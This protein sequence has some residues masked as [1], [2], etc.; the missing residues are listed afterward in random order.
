VGAF[1]GLLSLPREFFKL[2]HDVIVVRIM[3][4]QVRPLVVV[5]PRFIQMDM[6]LP[7]LRLMAQS[8]RGVAQRV[9]R[10]VE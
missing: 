1:V 4:A 5:I 7:H 2:P 9:E 8:Q 3:E 10:S 6:P